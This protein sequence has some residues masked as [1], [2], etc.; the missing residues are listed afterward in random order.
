MDVIIIL[1][2]LHLSH[3]RLKVIFKTASQNC[4]PIIVKIGDQE[5]IQ[6]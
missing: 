6:I 2:F 3:P 4:L 5:G 1:V